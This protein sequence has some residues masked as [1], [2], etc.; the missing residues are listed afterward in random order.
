MTERKKWYELAGMA[1]NIEKTS[2][3]GFG[4]CPEPLTIN[5]T[6]IAPVSS[7]KFLGMTIEQSLGLDDHVKIV[8]SKIR[9]AAA[10]IRADGSSFSTPD[11]RRLY[12]G[13]VQGVLCSNGAAYLPLLNQTQ[14][15]T[16]QTACNCA[17]RSVAKLPRKSKDISISDVRQCLNISSVKTLANKAVLTQAWK[18]RESFN[19][20]HTEG[21]QTR[22]RS[23]GNIPIIQTKRVFWAKWSPPKLS[24]HTTI[25]PNCARL[26]NQKK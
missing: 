15:D 23:I 19:S 24:A 10:K 14:L 2:I 20:T 6:T 1:L 11:R 22:S 26:K 8:A 13:W 17:I 25:F 4:F 3:I 7:F 9:A 21:P 18:N 12:M 16:L 5:N